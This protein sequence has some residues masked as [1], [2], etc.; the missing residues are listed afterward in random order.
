MRTSALLIVMFMAAYI[1]HGQSDL[2][3]K[4]ISAKVYTQGAELKRSATL[5]LKKGKN[6][7]KLSKLSANLDPKTIQVSGEDITI[8]SVR[9]EKDFIETNTPEKVEKLLEQKQSL[10]D[11]IEVLD[12][13]IFILQKEAELL[14]K[15]MKVIGNEGTNGEEYQKALEYFSNKFEVNTNKSFDLKLEVRNL[16]KQVNEIDKQV[17][18]YNVEED[19]PTS[20]IFLVINADKAMKREVKIS[21]AVSEAGWFP[22]YDIRATTVNNPLSLTYKAR[23]F[24]NTG[25]DWKDIKLTLS[26]GNLEVSGTAPELS[27]FYLGRSNQVRYRYSAQGQISGRVVGS[28]D[29]LPLPQVSVF[30][31][32]STT[33]TPTDSDGYYS[34]QVPNGHN[35]L[36]FRFLGYVTQ[37]IPIK[38]QSVID[39]ALVPD[40]TSLG[41]VVVTGVAAAT[42]EKKLTFSVARIN[43]NDDY[44]YSGNAGTALRGKVAGVRVRSARDSENETIQIRGASQL[45]A[46]KR[47]NKPLPINHINYQTT[48]VYEIEH[49]YDIPSTG[50]PEVVDIQ[51]LDVEANY[52]YSTSP[53]AKE[54][55]YLVAEIPEWEKLKLLDGESNLYFEE[56]FVGKSIID[57]NIGKDTLDIS[58]GKDEGIVV[59][60]KRLKEFEKQKF[61]SNKKR[62]ERKF[63]ITIVNTKATNININ[64]YD[65]IPVVPN[66]NFR[67][68]PEDLAE[69]KVDKETGLLAWNIQLNPGEKRVIQFSYS[70][71]YPKHMDLDID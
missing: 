3:S 27:P 28:D 56:S 23:V 48:F 67:V 4:L 62:D 10:M 68:I 1:V 66:R 42:P 40:A 33:G 25:I 63:E 7:F 17:S 54:N 34:M 15:N 36:V 8:L 32:G 49:P 57:T 50:Q 46:P 11:K 13:K 5:D 26:S 58:L 29:G 19:E 55:A 43:M 53:K 64:V 65:Q 35:S 6:E 61:F 69:A 70:V 41:E 12:M 22:A 71:E 59:S 52:I 24:Q 16:Q 14:S 47:E 31:K 37:E 20:N 38:N 51:T 60:R 2:E 30:V 18:S 21:Y 44:V 9:H 45:R 39:V